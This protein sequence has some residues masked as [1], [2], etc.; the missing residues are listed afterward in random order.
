M[1][2]HLLDSDEPLVAGQDQ[3]ALCGQ[4][5]SKAYF[6]FCLNVGPSLGNA[7][8]ARFF[9]R[10]CGEKVG[11][12]TGNYVYSLIDGEQAKHLEAEL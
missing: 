2:A 9:C 4:V 6:V 5:V 10:K 8:S 3:T 12:T 11:A 1:K 7:L